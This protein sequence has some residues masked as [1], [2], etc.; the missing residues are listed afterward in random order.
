MERFA[1]TAAE[2]QEALGLGRSTVY[3][4]MQRSDFPTVRIG[5]KI[6]VPIAE[7][8]HWLHEQAEGKGVNVK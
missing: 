3:A 2:L 8:Q 6:L 1:L 5:R 7:L 4:L